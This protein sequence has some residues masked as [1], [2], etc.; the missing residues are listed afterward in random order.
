MPGQ[1]EERFREFVAA[2]GSALFRVALA[3]TGGPQAAQ[4]LVQQ[5][6]TQ[7]W[8]RWRSVRGQPEAYVRKTM[9]HLQVTAWRRKFREV[10]VDSVPD[11][12]AADQMSTVD[13]RLA[14]RRALARLGPRCWPPCSPVPVD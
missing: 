10:P 14:L 9:Y 6:L 12:P 2:R 11:R 8:S 1:D 13:L 4:D 3:L 7:T 5:A